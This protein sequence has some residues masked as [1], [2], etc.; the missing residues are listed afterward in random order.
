MHEP[1]G[2]HFVVFEKSETICNWTSVT[3]IQLIFSLALK[4]E[5]HCAFGFGF[6]KGLAFYPFLLGNWA[7]NYRK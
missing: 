2:L 4:D 1:I 5:L 7:E 6:L 3:K